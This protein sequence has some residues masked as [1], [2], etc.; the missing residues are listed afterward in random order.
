[1]FID[2]DLSIEVTQAAASQIAGS[3]ASVLPWKQIGRFRGNTLLPL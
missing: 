3:P 1:M 2:I